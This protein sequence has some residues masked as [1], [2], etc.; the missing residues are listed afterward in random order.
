MFVCVALTELGLSKVHALFLAFPALP[1]SSL[2]VL[3]HITDLWREI[4]LLVKEGVAEI[5]GVADLDKTQLEELY[6]W[7]SVKP[8]VDQ[9]NLAHCCTIPEVSASDW[10]ARWIAAI[11]SVT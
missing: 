6:E 4:E 11:L 8:K 9:V 10:I 5:V 2:K 7:A 3:E 1:N